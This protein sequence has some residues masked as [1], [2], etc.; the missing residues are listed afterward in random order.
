MSDSTK[1]NSIGFFGVLFLIFLVLKLIGIINWSW[2]LVSAP[3][4][5]P[6]VLV[7]VILLIVGIIAK[8]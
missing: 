1:S 4:W 2:W 3:L 7:F 6:F 8:R 5:A